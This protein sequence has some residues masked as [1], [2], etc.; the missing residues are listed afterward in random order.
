MRRSS[1]AYGCTP[2]MPPLS[3][4]CATGSAASRSP[5][6]DGGPHMSLVTASIHIDAPPRRV[7]EMVMDPR[8]LHEWVTIHRKL[9]RADDGP[10]RIGY[11]MDQLLH[12]RGVNLEVH[13][14]LVECEPP[15]LAV[16]E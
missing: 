4:R 5:R 14:K 12:L 11:R 16:W 9:V 10:A 1:S 3:G 15:T 8:R 2:S 7:W 13:W 6:D